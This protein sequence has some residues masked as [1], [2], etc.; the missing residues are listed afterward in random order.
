MNQFYFMQ[1]LL[2]IKLKLIYALNISNI[3]LINQLRM[4][5]PSVKR[6][7]SSRLSRSPSPSPIKA[8]KKI[9]IM[10]CKISPIRFDTPP[11]AKSSEFPLPQ[12]S[13]P[14]FDIFSPNWTSSSL[15]YDSPQLGREF[16]VEVKDYYCH[17]YGCEKDFLALKRNFVKEEPYHS[18]LRRIKGKTDET[19]YLCED[20]EWEKYRNGFALSIYNGKQ[21]RATAVANSYDEP[22][23]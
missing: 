3:N 16:E 10:D 11:P 12:T 13:S 17:C 8:S 6:S 15:I 18:W 22:I 4:S 21:P 14:N 23:F 7:S 5:L 19:P 2:I 9:K 20:C 1:N